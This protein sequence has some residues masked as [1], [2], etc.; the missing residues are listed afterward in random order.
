[1][2]IIGDNQVQ[3]SIPV[4]IEESGAGAPGPTADSSFAGNIGKGAITVV[5]IQNIGA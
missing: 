1:M 3:V 4:V 5:A 2:E